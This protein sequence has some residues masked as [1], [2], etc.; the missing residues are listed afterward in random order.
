MQKEA[1]I[2]GTQCITLRKETEWTDTL[3]DN[4]NTLTGTNAFKIIQA[5]DKEPSGRRG[6][7]FGDG[8]ACENIC[9]LLK[10][11]L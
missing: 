2:L 9:H 6:K 3:H 8:T 1:Y 4:W 11:Q 10:T 7:F 5:A